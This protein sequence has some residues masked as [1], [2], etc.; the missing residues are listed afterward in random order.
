MPVVIYSGGRVR[1][2]EILHAEL[3]RIS[4]G[5]RQ[6]L[7]TYI[8][9]CHEDSDVFFKRAVTRYRR[10]GFTDFLCMPVDR[11]I[12]PETLQKALQ[13][14]VIYLAGGNTFY[15]LSHLKKSGVFA[16]L[17][18]YIAKGGTV[19]GLSAGAIMLTPN[20]GLA[21]Y[22]E[23]DRDENDVGL[24]DLRALNAVPFEFF[25]H[26]RSDER[27]EQALLLYS[28]NSPHPVI[29]SR[30]GSGVIVTEGQ[31]QFVGDNRLFVSGKCVKI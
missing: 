1:K 16:K 14:E 19:A 18:S 22:P 26:Y 5:T 6:K 13:G 8:P 10:F 24:R 9:Y 29:A 3:A 7:F 28:K 4:S 20:I 23:F 11:K 15:F 31:T 17:R 30:D 12:D 21:G 27:V 25:P 2:N